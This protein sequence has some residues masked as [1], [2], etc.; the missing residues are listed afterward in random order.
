MAHHDFAEGW[1]WCLD[2]KKVLQEGLCKR[3]LVLGEMK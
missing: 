1:F 3:K 2:R